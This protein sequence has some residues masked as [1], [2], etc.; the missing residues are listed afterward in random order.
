MP[1]SKTITAPLTHSLKSKEVFISCLQSTKTKIATIKLMI[2]NQC[3]S[4]RDPLGEVNLDLVTV[5]GH[6]HGCIKL[7]SLCCNISARFRV[8]S[9]VIVSSQSMD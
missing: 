1:F 3:V 2:M 8:L 5:V 4:K 6:S 7:S 9:N